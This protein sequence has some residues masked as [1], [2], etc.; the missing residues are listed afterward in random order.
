MFGVQQNQESSFISGPKE[1]KGKEISDTSKEVGSV[2]V[3]P[4]VVCLPE[5]SG[6]MTEFHNESVTPAS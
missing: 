4:K 1:G 2:G 5:S 6:T 3:R